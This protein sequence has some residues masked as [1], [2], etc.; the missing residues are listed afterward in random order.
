[1]AKILGI[2]TTIIL[3]MLLVIEVKV[4]SSIIQNNTSDMHSIGAIMDITARA[5]KEARVAME[6]AIHDFNTKMKKN[7]TLFTRNSNGNLV[8]AIRE[9]NYQFITHMLLH[10]MLVVS[11]FLTDLRVNKFIVL[12]LWL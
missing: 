4:V 1:M 10:I 6:I 2:S 8:H 7:L 11:Y 12:I 3:F 9:G 5:G